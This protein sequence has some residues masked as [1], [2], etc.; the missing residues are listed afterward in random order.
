MS[1]ATPV[2]VNRIV[3]ILF[4]IL[5]L[6]AIWYYTT[7]NKLGAKPWTWVGILAVGWWLTSVQLFPLIENL[8]EKIVPSAL[9]PLLWVSLLVADI[10]FIVLLRSYLMR[11]NAFRKAPPPR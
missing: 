6:S 5:L 3:L 7:A 2:R 1:A 9:E 10:G 4:P 8:L 11:R